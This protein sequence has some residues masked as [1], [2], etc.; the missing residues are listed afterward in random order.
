MFFD[1]Q[2]GFAQFPHAQ[3]FGQ[4][5]VCGQPEC[6]TRLTLDRS[7]SSKARSRLVAPTGR[8]NSHDPFNA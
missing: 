2:P 6:S 5:D 1:F 3:R 8:R 7:R 4:A